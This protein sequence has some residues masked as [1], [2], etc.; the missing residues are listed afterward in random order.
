MAIMPE[1]EIDQPGVCSICGEEKEAE[2]LSDLDGQIACLDCIAEAKASTLDPGLQQIAAATHP[3]PA[4]PS[5]RR[6]GKLGW[7]VFILFVI[8]LVAVVYHFRRIDQRE[9]TFRAS[10]NSLKTEGDR[11]ASAGKYDESLARY[12][13]VLKQLQGR[14]LNHPQLVYLYH[15]T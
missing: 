5:P 2:E 3:A 4:P 6:R 12:E 10:I 8:G 1:F 13:A 15:E 9:A 7:L 11:L 14:P